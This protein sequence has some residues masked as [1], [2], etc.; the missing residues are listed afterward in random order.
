MMVIF[1][2][3]LCSTKKCIIKIYSCSLKYFNGKENCFPSKWIN[4]LC[5]FS[6]GISMKR[7]QSTFFQVKTASLNLDQKWCP[8]QWEDTQH[9]ITQIRSASLHWHHEPSPHNQNTN[10]CVSK[11]ILNH[12]YSQDPSRQNCGRS[13]ASLVSLHVSSGNVLIALS[14]NTDFQYICK[15]QQRTLRGRSDSFLSITEGYSAH[16]SIMALPLLKPPCAL[17]CFSPT[18]WT[19]CWVPTHRWCGR[20]Q[21]TPTPGHKAQLSSGLHT[22]NSEPGQAAGG[23]VL[24][25]CHDEQNWRPSILNSN[26]SSLLHLHLKSAPYTGSQI[27]ATK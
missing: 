7:S 3:R 10:P 26:T 21:L 14:S 8:L 20:M 19:G 17:H 11:A 9:P 13:H 4:Y 6:E 15:M 23:W 5:Y 2:S 12:R 27:A 18:G 1:V 25:L 16:F 24:T 22:R